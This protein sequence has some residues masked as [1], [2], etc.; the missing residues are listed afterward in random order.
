[1]YE[2]TPRLNLNYLHN[3]LVSCMHVLSITAE[4]SYTKNQERL[5]KNSCPGVLVLTQKLIL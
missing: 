1:M 4:R 2:A 3:G 5:E